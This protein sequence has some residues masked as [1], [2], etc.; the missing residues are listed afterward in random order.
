ME[1]VRFA[2]PGFFLRLVERFLPF[3]IV[4][5]GLLLCVGLYFSFVSPPD[6]QQGDLVRIMYVHVPMA[7]LSMACYSVIALS[8]VGTLVWR[9][10]LA[11][12]SAKAAIPV[13]ATF[14]ALTLVT[15]SIWARPT[16][17]V[18]WVWD[19]RLTS[20]LL[21]FLLYLGLLALS[22]ALG[23]SARAG[24]AV[25]VMALV[26]FVNVPIIKFSVEWWNTAHQPASVLRMGGPA[27][28]SS[29]MTPLLIMALGF[30][31][32]FLTLHLMA[33]RNEILRRRVH[34]LRR[35][36]AARSASEV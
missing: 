31:F 35:M 16:W 2:N 1:L 10:P 14:T 23:D 7:W 25:A 8:A 15:G 33:M 6:Y 29:M 21:L 13:G 3:L 20:V 9:H 22:R 26:G 17:G 19:A 24:R 34:A 27:I 28:H 18:L 5:S 4:F 32:M 30:S 36:Q 11:D 12:V